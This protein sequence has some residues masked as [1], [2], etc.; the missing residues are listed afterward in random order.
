MRGPSSGA[1]V[2]LAIGETAL[3]QVAESDMVRILFCESGELMTTR[4]IDDCAKDNINKMYLHVLCSNESAIEFYKSNG[5][6]TRVGFGA[7]LSERVG[8]FLSD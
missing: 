2:C 5:F 8:V 4:A 7:S 6:S 1:A 3:S